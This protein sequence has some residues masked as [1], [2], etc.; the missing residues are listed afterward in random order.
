MSR[1]WYAVECRR[2]RDLRFRRL[3]HEA[4]LA[5]FYLEGLAGDQVP[6][7]L[8]RDDV[9]AMGY[10]QLCGWKAAGL[11]AVMTEL[12]DTDWL[13][14]LPDGRVGL[15][16][17]DAVQTALNERI[18]KALEAVRLRNWRK[19]KKGEKGWDELDD[20]LLDPVVTVVPVPQL[21]DGFSHTTHTTP[22]HTTLQ[23][24]TQQEYVRRTYAGEKATWRAPESAMAPAMAPA[25]NGPEGKLVA[26]WERTL[27]KHGEPPLGPEHVS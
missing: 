20:H 25:K 7:A 23:D 19:K 9:E 14:T 6:E 13:D 2:F 10:L 12:H 8:W 15:P 4:Q 18:K 5:V 21:E 22:Q 26:E 3:S 16:E 24:S 11:P 17:W 27:K 1:E